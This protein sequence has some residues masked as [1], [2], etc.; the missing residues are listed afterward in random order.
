MSLLAVIAYT[1][2]LFWS[3]S[4]SPL[5]FEGLPFEVVLRD[6]DPLEMG[7]RVQVVLLVEYVGIFLAAE[8][9]FVLMAIKEYLQDYLRL[10]DADLIREEEWRGELSADA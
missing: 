8:A 1:F 7:P 2:T 10:E 6:T 9:A 4:M 5:P 3:T